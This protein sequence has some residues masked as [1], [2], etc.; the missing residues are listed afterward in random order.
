MILDTDAVSITVSRNVTLRN[1]VSRQ[2]SEG[3]ASMFKIENRHSS[4]LKMKA[5]SFLP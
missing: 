2:H 5:S 3:T 4:T 1:F